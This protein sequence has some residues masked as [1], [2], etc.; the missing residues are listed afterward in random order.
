MREQLESIAAQTLLPVELVVCD[1]GSTDDTMALVR[2]FA[3]WAP[4]AVRLYGNENRLGVIANYSRTVSLCRGD[5]IALC[6][7]DD[8]WRPEKLELSLDYMRG[9]EERYGQKTP[10]LVH[11]DLQVVDLQ[12][13]F[14]AASM[15]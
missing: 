12:G 1:D 2:D 3:R 11:S 7:Q 6:D 10:L 9:A 13:R 4:F 8:L 15:M 5:Y 14:M